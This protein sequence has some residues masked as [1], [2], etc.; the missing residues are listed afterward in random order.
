M[1]TTNFWGHVDNSAYLPVKLDVQLTL[2]QA[3]PTRSLL[4]VIGAQFLAFLAENLGD[5]ATMSG[6]T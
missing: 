6:Q 1:I 5:A 4:A 3:Q 2:S